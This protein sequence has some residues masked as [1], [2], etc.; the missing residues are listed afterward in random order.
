[1]Y[2]MSCLTLLTAIMLQSCSQENPNPPK[3][4]GNNIRKGD[5][6]TVYKKP[7]VPMDSLNAQTDKPKVIKTSPKIVKTKGPARQEPKAVQTPS[8]EPQPKD[9]YVNPSMPK[10][11]A[12]FKTDPKW[13]ELYSQSITYYLQS[14]EKNLNAN[15][16]R[17]TTQETLVREYKEKMSVTFYKTPEFAEYAK[18]KFEKSE[19]LQAFTTQH[20][21]Q[22]TKD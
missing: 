4:S 20:A 14:V 10:W 18:Q 17:T 21:Q 19:A 3:D 12:S 9:N 16:G 15:P 22:I 2:K 6:Q 11:E 5:D 13:E 7:P 1:M 8:V